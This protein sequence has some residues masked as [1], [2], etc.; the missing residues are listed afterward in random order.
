M[1]TNANGGDHITI[2][3]TTT[4]VSALPDTVSL[5]YEITESLTNVTPSSDPLGFS[6]TFGPYTN[7]FLNKPYTSSSAENIGEPSHTISSVIINGNFGVLMTFSPTMTDDPVTPPE[8]PEDGSYQLFLQNY[9]D[10]T[11]TLKVTTVEATDYG[12]AGTELSYYWP[13]MTLEMHS[14]PSTAKLPKPATLD[15][16]PEWPYAPDNDTVDKGNFWGDNP[17]FELLIG[18]IS[19]PPPDASDDSLQALSVYLNSGGSQ[20][21]LQGNTYTIQS[22]YDLVLYR[23]NSS[24][25]QTSATTTLTT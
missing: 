11:W 6:G 17:T 14:L 21:D 2:S 23:G 22:A 1:S 19:A 7:N 24:G 16:D 4:G 10:Q 9:K 15:G 12:P 25:I 5:F 8:V 3:P 20:V 18:G 13:S